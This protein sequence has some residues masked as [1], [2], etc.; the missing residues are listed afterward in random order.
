MASIGD[1]SKYPVLPKIIWKMKTTSC[2]YTWC[3][4]PKKKYIVRI[5]DF[6]EILNALQNKVE[7][8]DDLC[9]KTFLKYAIY[10]LPYYLRSSL[11]ISEQSKRL[12]ILFWGAL[13]ACYFNLGSTV[14][15]EKSPMLTI[16]F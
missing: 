16:L 10:F 6:S 1:F 12:T 4:P 13:Y 15:F 14:Y 11:Y 5:E 3:S 7:N 2:K 8:K 9:E